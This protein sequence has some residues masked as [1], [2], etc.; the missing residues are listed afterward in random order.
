MEFVKS[1]DAKKCHVYKDVM[2]E[3]GLRVYV[4]STCQYLK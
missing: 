1:N 3:E 4:S 2:N